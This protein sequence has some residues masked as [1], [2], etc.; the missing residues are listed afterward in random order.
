[1]IKCE[2]N[3]VNFTIKSSM[4]LKVNFPPR[5]STDSNTNPIIYG[6]KAVLDCSSTENPP[7]TLVKWNFISINSTK[8]VL[9]DEKNDSI[10]EIKEAYEKDEGSYECIIENELG[11]INRNFLIS[12][13]PIGNLWRV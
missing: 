1:M 2:A 11:K 7:K 13:T 8:P 10:L 6:S 9:I 4:I 3:C 12:L 5:F